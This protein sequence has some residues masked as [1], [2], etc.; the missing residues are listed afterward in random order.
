MSR[1]NRS[2]YLASSSINLSPNRLLRGVWVAAFAN[3]LNPPL[4]DPTMVKGSSLL[5]KHLVS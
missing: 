3:P 5:I 4:T 2:A 1:I